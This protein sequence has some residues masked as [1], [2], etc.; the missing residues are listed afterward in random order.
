MP[1][2]GSRRVP[3]V[4][5][6]VEGWRRVLAAPAVVAGTTAVIWASAALVATM[7]RASINVLQNGLGVPRE[8]GAWVILLDREFQTL[9]SVVAP[10]VSPFFGGRV[11]AA[12]LASIV[13]QAGLWLF[14]SGGVLDR[15]ARGR[16][17]RT[18]AF[19]AACGVFFFRFV[20][21]TA[22]VS[23]VAFLLLQA[24][25][26]STGSIVQHAIVAAG[27]VVFTFI[28]DF[29]RV[30]AVVEDRW[31]MVGALVAALRFVS[32]RLVRVLA[33]TALNALVMLA[34]VRIG[35]Q[36]GWT[37]APG[38]LSIVLLLLWLLLAVA[39]RLAALASEA[40]FFQGELAHAGYT[41]GPAFTWPD[42]PAVE[43]MRDLRTQ[44]DKVNE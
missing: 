12:V 10:E 31:S 34:L 28:S 43:A 38:W 4:G 27:A 36:I 39:A 29:A 25:R 13:V 7:S 33:L 26:L 30:R 44:G 41:A 17:I 9:T 18:A 37:P 5:A 24:S 16:P 32:R 35:M 42:S 6:F 14:L 1:A 11:P 20:R 8:V 19:F 2:P 23:A 22:M 40:V 3:P 21:L 15:L